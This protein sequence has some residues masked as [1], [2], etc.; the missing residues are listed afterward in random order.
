M[1]S[2]LE[3]NFDLTVCEVLFGI[4]INND[5]NMKLLNF[6]IIITK[7]YI[8]KTKVLE[9]QLFFIELLSY[10]RKKVR[11][12][13]YINSSRGVDGLRWHNALLDVI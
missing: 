12:I 10:I 11:I 4:P 9:K 1:L 13:E 7:S 2:N 5:D 6:F 8:N 3:F